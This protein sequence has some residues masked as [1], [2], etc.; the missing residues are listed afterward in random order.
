[1]QEKYS[2]GGAHTA[3]T[4]EQCLQGGMKLIL[5]CICRRAACRMELAQSIIT[6]KLP[7]VDLQ[8]HHVRCQD[9]PHADCTHKPSK[10]KNLRQLNYG[11]EHRVYL[12]VEQKLQEAL[13]GVLIILIVSGGGSKWML[14]V[15]V[16]DNFLKQGF[17]FRKRVPQ[18]L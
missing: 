14:G 17:V 5:I 2:L 10:R 18:Q 8:E 6:A 1:M 3:L 16:P 7:K 15:S 12:E 9:Q 4:L 11:N 13:Q